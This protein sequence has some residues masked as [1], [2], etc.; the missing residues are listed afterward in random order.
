MSNFDIGLSGLNAAQRALDVIGNNVANAATEGYHRQRV[1]LTPA[2]ASQNG[3][4]MIG[5]GVDVAGVTRVINNLLEDEIIR[6]QSS[7]EQVS[8]ELT[9]MK[10]V[11]NAFGE[12]TTESGGLN[13]AIDNFFN[14]LQ[15]L[16]NHPGE[17]IWQNKVLTA[18]EA[19][20]GQF[21]TLGKFLSTMD[22]QVQIEAENTVQRCNTLIEQIAELN[23][24]IKRAEIGSDTEA[25]SLRD[26]RDQLVTELSKL[27]GVQTVRREYGVVDVVAGGIL[28]VADTSAI[29]LEVGLNEAGKLGV[30]MAG[31]Y[32]YNTDSQGGQLGG[33]LSL[34]NELVGN[35]RDDL[36]NLACSIIQ[37]VN[38]YHVQGAGSEGSFTELTGWMMASQSLADFNPPVTDGKIYIR[39]INTATGEISRQTIDVDASTDTLSTLAT[40][41]S[42]I[43]G[44]TASVASSKL[45][46]Q[47]SP[48]YKFDFLPAVL[49][50]PNADTLNLTGV[51]PPAVSISGIYTGTENQT[52]KFKVIGTGTV[53]NGSLQ[54]E[55]KNGAGEVVTTFNIGSGYA[56]GDKLDLGNGIKVTIGTGDLNNE[57]SF[58]VDAFGNT[59][60]SGVLAAAGI[61][62]L[63]SGS[64]AS[65][66]AVSSDVADN[67]ARIATALGSDMN[68]NTN[69]LRLAG[70]KNQNI[71]DLK[72][73]TLGDFYRQIVTDIGQEISIKQMRQDNVQTMV[74]N[75]SDQQGQ[76]SGVNI[77][78]EAAQ[79]MVFQQMFQAMAKYINTV[80]TSM[81]SLMDI[82]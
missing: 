45:H 7:Q 38:Q 24:N 67:P 62:T 31:S 52:F 8:Q 51:S 26:Q 58:E 2:Y 34:K 53:G 79:M 76:I 25:S 32:I 55:V 47:A 5:G 29:K 70:L 63:F 54:L 28:V 15:D 77:N 1:E 46:I 49:P 74:R 65:T 41:I 81:S 82:L 23:D 33:L 43:T 75:L 66:M 4:V 71:G 69:V 64:N 57:D 11:E 56:A 30:G 20:A 60:T 68:D 80:Q 73:M 12:L 72:N 59:D 18:A 9:T 22:S 35:V 16:S 10:T 48:N 44:L 42:A 6:Q 78:D 21:G 37:Q 39:V 27:I 61:N 14:A 3:T 19:M 36:D 17:S 13:A 50:L 40:K